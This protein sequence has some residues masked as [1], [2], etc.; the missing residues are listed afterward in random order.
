MSVKLRTKN[1]KGGRK[2]LYLDIYDNGRREYEFLNMFLE[3]D[4]KADREILEY[5]EAIRVKRQLEISAGKHGF[6][7]RFK[8]K[9]DFVQYFEGLAKERKHLWQWSNTLKHLREFSGGKVRFID[10]NEKWLEEFQSYLL[11]H[12]SRNSARVYF[13]TLKAAL[14]KAVNS[15]IINQNPSQKVSNIKGAE[16]ETVYLTVDEV[17]K[18]SISEC[19]KIE[20]KKAFLFACVT[21][22]RFS[23]LKRLTW[24]QI[25]NDGTRFHL[26]FRPQKT[27]GFEYFPLGKAAQNILFGNEDR[28]LIHLHPQ[29][30]KVF[31]L[32]RL[33][34]YNKI[35]KQ[36]AKKAGIEKKL[37]SH[38]GRHTFATMELTQGVEIYTVSKLLG[39][40]DLN[41]TQRYAKVIDQKKEEAVDL[42]PEIK[43]S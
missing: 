35:L 15:G 38:V 8:K 42:L 5:A 12:V 29:N 1:L 23:D 40:K 41:T 39:H 19:P 37:S 28:K 7:P 31:N 32:P 4:K 30:Q 34:T 25:K 17:H 2:S 24:N 36:W 26:A 14:K 10:I 22:L 16:I 18:L 9:A 27:G 21:G 13:A 33:D 43:I 20:I 11:K 6:T 3:G